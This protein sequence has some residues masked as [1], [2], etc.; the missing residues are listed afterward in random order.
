MTRNEA[1]LAALLDGDRST[2]ELVAATGLTERVC[3]YGL[4]HLIGTDY[5][6]SPARGRYRLTARGR[7]IAGEIVPDAADAL[8]GSGGTTDASETKPTLRR[9]FPRRR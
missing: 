3:R 8:G 9:R 5:V 6:W 4:R 2:L 7:V 1:L